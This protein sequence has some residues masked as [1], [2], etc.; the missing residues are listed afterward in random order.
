MVSYSDESGPS[1]LPFWETVKFMK[2]IFTSGNFHY[3][4]GNIFQ[5]IRLRTGV[6]APDYV[7]K[8]KKIA[9]FTSNIFHFCKW[10]KNKTDVFKSILALSTSMPTA[11]TDAFFSYCTYNLQKPHVYLKFPVHLPPPTT[12]DGG[13]WAEKINECKLSHGEPEK[14]WKIYGERKW[15]QQM[16]STHD[17]FTL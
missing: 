8:A 9:L 17:D 1:L 2:G 5:D 15:I 12:P 16:S 14:G 3:I 6:Q 4:R 11:S 10:V 13:Q 7:V